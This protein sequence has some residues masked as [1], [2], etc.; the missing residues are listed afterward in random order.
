MGIPAEYRNFVSSLVW[1]ETSTYMRIL[2]AVLFDT[3]FSELFQVIF[4]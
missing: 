4:R 1:M 2:F 3:D